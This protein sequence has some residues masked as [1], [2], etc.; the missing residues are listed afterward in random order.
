MRNVA[1]HVLYF[2]SGQSWSLKTAVSIAGEAQLG[3]KLTPKEE[4]G[5]FASLDS[6]RNQLPHVDIRPSRR[7]PSQRRCQRWPNGTPLRRKL[8]TSAERSTLGL[9]FRRP[10]PGGRIPTKASDC[11]KALNRGVKYGD[12]PLEHRL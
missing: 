12:Q 2:H 4:N 8:I 6:L 10:S 7:A 1:L 9:T 3:A 11:A 5:V